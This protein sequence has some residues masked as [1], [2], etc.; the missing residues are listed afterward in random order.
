MSDLVEVRAAVKA[1]EHAEGRLAEMHGFFEHGVEHGREVAGRGV[2]DLQY[3]GGR[4]LLL[5]RLALFGEAPGIFHGERG[6]RGE[7]LDQ[8]DLCLREGAH[9]LPIED[10]HADRPVFANE[11]YLDERAN[12]PQ[13]DAGHCHWQAMLEV[14]VDLGEIGD[15]AGL[16][17]L[18]DAGCRAFRR[19]GLRFGP[20]LDQSRG[21]I[22]LGQHREL[23]V[24][25]AEEAAKRRI[26]QRHR[27]RDDQVE[28]RREIAG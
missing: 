11:G 21:A 19:H 2:D 18:Q 24:F 8:G 6:L 1:V 15:L 27:P 10:E 25:V 13:L 22:T 26:A 28:Y 17:F 16:A 7:R 23:L 5:E 20:I 4:G 3:L 12:V 9:L 14:G